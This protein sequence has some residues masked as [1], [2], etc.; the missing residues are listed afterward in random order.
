MKVLRAGTDY[1]HKIQWQ[2]ISIVASELGTI[3][4][5]VSE[6]WEAQE[7][8]TVLGRTRTRKDF[9]TF[10]VHLARKSK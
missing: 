10:E 3:V 2:Y 6:G 9:R 7:I 5:L 1:E 8:K 4:K